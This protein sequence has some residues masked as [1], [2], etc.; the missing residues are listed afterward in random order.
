MYKQTITFDDVLLEPQYSDIISR[1]QVDIHGT[2]DDRSKALFLPIIS[3][4]MDTVTEV[5]MAINMHRLGGLGIIHRYNTIDEQCDLVKETLGQVATVGAAIGVTSDYLERAAALYDAGVR[6]LCVDVAHGHHIMMKNALTELR[7]ILGDDLHIMA[8]NVGTLEGFNAL[9]DW[10]ADSIRVGIGG[11][12]ICSTRIQTG[13]G[14]PTLQSVL[15]CGRSDRDARLIADG[16]I[17]TSGDIVK[18]IAAGADFVILGSLLG[19]CEEAPGDTFRDRDGRCFKTYRGMA[20]AAAQRDWRGSTA[21]LEG[22]ST[23]VPCKGPVKKVVEDLV[24]GIRS[25]FSYSGART[26][27]ELQAKAKFI[28]QSQASSIESTTHILHR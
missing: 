16:G 7:G 20:S 23:T 12:S 3:S 9:A 24:T 13:H 26:K 18:A 6:V 4:P 1:S 25:G 27:E 10:G 5:E 19:G 2:I 11:G 15:E 22:V 21:S 28:I 17:K 8:G 14:I